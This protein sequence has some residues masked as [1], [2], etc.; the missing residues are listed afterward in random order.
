MKVT[1]DQDGCIACGACEATCSEVFVLEDDTAGIVEKYRTGSP[2][3]GEVP[4]NLS[5]CAGD[6]ANSCPVQVI[7]AE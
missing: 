1:I 7:T 5:D 4:D 6:A 3:E 2:T